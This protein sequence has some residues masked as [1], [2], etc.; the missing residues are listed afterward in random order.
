[1]ASSETLE[2]DI[3]AGGHQL[4]AVA[5]GASQLPEESIDIDVSCAV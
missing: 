2:I 4:P 1:M 5:A 3:E